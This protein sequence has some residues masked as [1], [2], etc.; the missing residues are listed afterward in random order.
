MNVS[1]VCIREEE[2]EWV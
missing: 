2:G 1:Q